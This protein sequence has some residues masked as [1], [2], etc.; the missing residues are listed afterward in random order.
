MGWKPAA[1]G[2]GTGGKNG[3]LADTE[4]QTRA[5]EPA[6]AGRDGGG[7][8]SDAPEDGADAANAPD[9]KP[10]EDDTDGELAKGVGPVIRGGEHAEGGEGDAE[11]GVQRVLRNGKVDP[12][13]IVDQ[14]AEPEQPSNAPAAPR[15]GSEGRLREFR[16]SHGVCRME[17]W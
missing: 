1:D 6:D 14:N 7:E 10:V 5:E 11:G 13:Q 12:V 3:R 2:L 4:Q 15:Y 9:A 8:G 16:G 17:V